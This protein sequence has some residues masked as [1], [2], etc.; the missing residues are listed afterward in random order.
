MF[1]N[2]EVQGYTL[3][4]IGCPQPKVVDTNPKET[5]TAFLAGVYDFGADEVYPLHLTFFEQHH[6]SHASADK[7]LCGDED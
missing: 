7:F 6:D 2:G 4:P 5:V 3:A 1:V